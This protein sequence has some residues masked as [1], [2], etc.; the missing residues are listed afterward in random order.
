M[1]FDLT[2][3]QTEIKNVARE[4]L[5]ARS[6]MAKV[7]EAAEAGSYDAALWKEIVELG[8]PGIAV[9]ESF[10]GQGLERSSSRCCSRNSATHA[11][12]HR[13]CRPRSPPR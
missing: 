11:L 13:F 2:E 3:D 8:W 9:D 7:R 1:D 10:G 6:P 12:R 4:M 5:S